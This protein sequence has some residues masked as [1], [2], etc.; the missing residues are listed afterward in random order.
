M[1]QWVN[2]H[3]NVAGIEVCADSDGH[4]GGRLRGD[5]CSALQPSEDGSVR[6]GV[7]HAFVF[8]RLSDRRST[9]I[10]IDG[11]RKTRDFGR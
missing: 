8:Q 4:L 1:L 11:C 3:H 10:V 9:F 2:T 6:Q 5:P 7:L